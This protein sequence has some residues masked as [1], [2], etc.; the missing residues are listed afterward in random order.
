[1]SMI[2]ED[3]EARDIAKKIDWLYTI[4]IIYCSKSSSYGLREW[5][6]NRKAANFY[7][8]YEAEYVEKVLKCVKHTMKRIS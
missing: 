8:D 3:E 5:L 1:M 4:P 2:I 7:F 6:S